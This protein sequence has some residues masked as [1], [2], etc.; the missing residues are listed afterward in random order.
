MRSGAGGRWGAGAVRGL[1][2][3]LGEAEG[4]GAGVG[5]LCAPARGDPALPA[6]TAPPPLA[7]CGHRGGAAL[8]C[9]LMR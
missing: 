6:H 7:L 3:C 9:H 1:S 8:L 4:G 5:V 2:L